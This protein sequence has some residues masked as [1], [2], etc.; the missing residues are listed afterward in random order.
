MGNHPIDAVFVNGSPVS[1]AAVRSAIRNVIWNFADAPTLRLFDLDNTPLVAVNAVSFKYDSTDLSTADDGV[2][3]IIDLAGRR[4]KKITLTVAGET[5]YRQQSMQAGTTAAHYKINTNGAPILSATPFL[6]IFVPDVNS[7]GACDLQLDAQA[8][9]AISRSNNAAIAAD[10][11][12]AG[13][14]YL[15]SVT[16]AQI[17]IYASGAT[18]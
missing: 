14:P 16:S 9:V 18:A 2:T 5:I 15:L 8:A 12:I 10:D 11:L 4:F 3:C 7:T 1:K 6:L 17:T 13:V